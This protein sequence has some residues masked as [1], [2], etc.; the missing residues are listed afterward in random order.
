MPQLLQA[1][2]KV[3]DGELRQ[4]REETWDWVREFWGPKL[5]DTRQILQILAAI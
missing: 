4:W 2:I 3:I 1:L 5:Q